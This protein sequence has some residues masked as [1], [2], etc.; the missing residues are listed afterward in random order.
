MSPRPKHP[1]AD[2]EKI[3][4]SLE[5]QGWRVEKGR[6]YYKVKCPCED[7][8]LSTVKCTPSDPRYPLNL[9]KKLTRETCWK[10]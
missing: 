3:L 1:R 8:H 7:K 10:E 5:V 9:R 4:R 6:K 2:L